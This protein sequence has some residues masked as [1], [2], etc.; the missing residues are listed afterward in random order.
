MFY[1]LNN[2][3]VFCEK[4]NIIQQMPYFLRLYIYQKLKKHKHG[5]RNYRQQF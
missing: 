4:I 3:F 5:T 2:R 1:F